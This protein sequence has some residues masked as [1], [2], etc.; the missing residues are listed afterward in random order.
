MVMFCKMYSNMVHRIHVLRVDQ[1]ILNTNISHIDTWS[2]SLRYT[3]SVA[4]SCLP[5]AYFSM[6]RVLYCFQLETFGITDR[7]NEHGNVAMMK[8]HIGLIPVIN[9]CTIPV[10]LPVH[11]F[12]LLRSR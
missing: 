2:G 4:F 1:H 5:Y 10:I 6:C 9:N 8:L 12:M 3:F 7:H 11:L